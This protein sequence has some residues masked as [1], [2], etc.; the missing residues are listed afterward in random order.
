MDGLL[1]MVRASQ[2]DSE[3]GHGDF[4]LDPSAASAGRRSG[5]WRPMSMAACR[6]STRA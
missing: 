5:R 3:I 2:V 6:S 4:L 1:L